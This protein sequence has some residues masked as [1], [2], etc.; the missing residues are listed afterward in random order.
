MEFAYR[1][2]GANNP[3]TPVVLLIHPERHIAE[4]F[5]DSRRA[6]ARPA[7]AHQLKRIGPQ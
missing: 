3:G 4:I 1:Q 6:S 7:T 5:L 2:L